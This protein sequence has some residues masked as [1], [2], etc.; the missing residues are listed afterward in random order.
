ML[1][2]PRKG[3]QE[4]RKILADLVMK[5]HMK[6]SAAYELQ[7]ETQ[8][9]AMD[10]GL[11]GSLESQMS[12]RIG[13]RDIVVFRGI[14][15]LGVAEQQR[16]IAEQEQARNIPLPEADWSPLLKN[17]LPRRD[18]TLVVKTMTFSTQGSRKS[19]TAVRPESRKLKLAQGPVLSRHKS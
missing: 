14:D 18:Q 13:S 9:K 6:S 8:L 3:T 4:G 2:Q 17:I 10:H 16:K 12:D 5:F 7:R 15:I 19:R 11:L 1:S